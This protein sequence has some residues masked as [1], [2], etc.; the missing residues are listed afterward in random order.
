MLL[1]VEVEFVEL[2][3]PPLVVEAKEPVELVEVLLSEVV[4]ELAAL[5]R[6]T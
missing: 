2:P 6:R 1:E 3:L 4:V 5:K